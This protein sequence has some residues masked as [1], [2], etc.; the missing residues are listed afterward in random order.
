MITPAD[1]KKKVLRIWESGKFLS[2][3]CSG[4]EMFP[5]DIPFGKKSGSSISD[6]FIETR[7]SIQ[8]LAD[9]SKERT[10][11]GYSIE[12]RTIS[13]RQLGRQNI[14]HRIFVETGDD[15]LKLCGKK[16]QFDEFKKAC[17][18]TKNELPDASGFMRD[19]PLA[20]IENLPAWDKIIRVCL[21]FKKN[22]EPQIYIRQIV[23]PGID[24]KFIEANKKIISVLLV[25]LDPDKYGTGPA[26]LSHHGFE[27]HFGLLYDE[28]LIR[29][30]ILDKDIFI[31]DMSDITLPLS[32]FSELKI[33][34]ERVFITENK[35]NGLAFPMVKKSIVIFGLGY[36]IQS[37]ADVSWIKKPEVFYWGDIDT[38]GFSILS[39]ARSIIPGCKSM[40]MDEKTLNAHIQSTVREPDSKRFTGELTC[41]TPEET[42]LFEKLKNNTFGENLRLEQ[43]LIGFDF[44]LKWLREIGLNEELFQ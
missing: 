34:A 19:K 21:Y 23:I 26:S 10:G 6:N 43:E 39:L 4:D 5:L 16:R 12:Y 22:P 3:W 30:R 24:T 44:L 41:L 32:Q 29:F 1:I 27:K 13:H 15:F 14:P 17:S 28:P 37:L 35:I 36:G 25:Y 2:A 42:D 31:N 8:L 11:H 33:D 20:V 38:H 18:L 40:L 9:S 7:D